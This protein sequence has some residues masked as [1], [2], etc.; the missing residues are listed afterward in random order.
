MAMWVILNLQKKKMFRTFFQF[1]PFLAMSSILSQKKVT[2]L[3][4]IL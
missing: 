2:H 3:F 4:N 1:Y